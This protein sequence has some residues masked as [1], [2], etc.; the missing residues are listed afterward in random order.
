MFCAN[1]WHA[2]RVHVIPWTRDAAIITHKADIANAP[3]GN[4]DNTVTRGNVALT[5]AALPAE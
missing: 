2:E 4:Y 3:A 1:R 5:A